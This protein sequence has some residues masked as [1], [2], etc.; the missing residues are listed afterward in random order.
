MNQASN[1]PVSYRYRRKKFSVVFG[2]KR[3]RIKP[4][5]TAKMIKEGDLSAP[6]SYTA[7]YKQ[8]LRNERRRRRVAMA[9]KM[10]LICK[11][12]LCC[13][14]TQKRVRFQIKMFKKMEDLKRG[15]RPAASKYL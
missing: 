8:K 12:E 5:V 4:W 2:T 14:I 6:A 10:G 9:K 13:K 11:E 7:E 15:Q 1:E 3:H